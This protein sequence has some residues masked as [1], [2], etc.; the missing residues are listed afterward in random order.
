MTR[1]QSLPKVR[2]PDT[3]RCLGAVD[4]DALAAAVGALSEKTWQE[5]DA[6]K[7]NAHRCFHHTR[8]V[9]FRF[10]AGNAWPWL[11]YTTPIGKEFEPLITPLMAQAAQVYGYREPV[12]PKAML[13]RLQAGHD[14]DAHTDSGPVH[15]LTHRIHVPLLTNS[16]ATLTVNGG[17]FQLRAGFAYE[18]NN[19]AEHRVRNRGDEDRIHFLFEVFDGSRPALKPAAPL[20]FRRKLSSRS[21]RA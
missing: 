7:E 2:K 19:L 6:R 8:H 11:Y 1:E 16:A 13:A 20:V 18:V 5:E 15:A 9:V 4:A 12:F 3:V 10:I 14:I 21:K 17:S